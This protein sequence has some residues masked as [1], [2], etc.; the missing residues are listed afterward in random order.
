MGSGVSCKKENNS[1]KL[2]K[3]DDCNNETW[4]KILRLFDRLDTDGTQSIEE[5]ELMGHI[6]DL[7]VKN[8]IRK[9]VIT[10]KT[11]HQKM[12]MK[13][14]KINAEMEFKIN[15]IKELADQNLKNIDLYL[16]SYDKTIARDKKILE[17]MTDKQKANKIK[18][19]I[20]GKKDSIE[21]WDFYNYMK[22]RTE[23]IPNIVW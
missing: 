8:N 22:N 13:K 10:K 3:P 2:I 16:D 11:L 19:A 9:L 6:A 4:E 17:E 12:E 7:H 21:F 14:Q 20:C 1:T 18:N 15:E 5:N 23:D